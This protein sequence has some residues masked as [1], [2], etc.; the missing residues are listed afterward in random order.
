MQKNCTNLLFIQILAICK[1]FLEECPSKFLV[2]WQ[3]L[4]QC[5]NF[6]GIII[7]LFR[8]KNKIF[9]LT[10]SIFNF[11]NFNV[12]FYFCFIVRTTYAVVFW[13]WVNQSFNALVNY[14]NRNANSPI[15]T[16]QLGFAYAS[17]TT[18]AMVTAIGCKNFWGKRANPL[19]AVGF[20]SLYFQFF[21][22][23]EICLY[24]ILKF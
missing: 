20:H 3:L 4:V 22:P 15:S 5:F 17:A 9:F 8:D 24:N 6:I 14:T 10:I 11:T 7:F 18:A 21:S 1:M 13:Q 19:L 16:V 23:C 2:E 12:D